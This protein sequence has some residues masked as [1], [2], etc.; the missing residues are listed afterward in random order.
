MENVNQRQE[1][2]NTLMVVPHGK[3]APAVGY[4]V[5]YD[6]ARPSYG[7]D[8]DDEAEPPGLLD[9]LRTLRRHKW[10]I[11][12]S[13]LGGAVL[14]ILAGL[15]MTPIYEASTSLEVL[16]V[17]DNFM[18]TKESSPV[19]TT[20]LT[21]E[22]SE[23]ETQVELLQSNAVLDR[24][25]AK[26]DPNYAK[27]KLQKVATTGWRSLFHMRDTSSL[28]DREV[29]LN[30]LADSLKVK[31][32]PRT[33]ILEVSARCKDPQLALEFVDTLASEFIE[34]NVESRRQTTLHVSDWL[35]SEIED[36]RAKL[37]RAEDALQAY[38]GTSGLI[39]TTTDAGKETNIAT[40]KLEQLQKALSDATADRITKEANYQLAKTSPPDA[41]PDVLNDQSLR[42]AMAAITALRGQIA[43]LN[44]RFTPEYSKLKSAQA[45]LVAL[46][47]D[48]D[49][50]RAAVIEKTKNDY[51]EAASKEKLLAGTYEAQTKEVAGQGEKAVQYNILK[52]DVES[53]GQLYYNMLQQ[54]KESSVASALHASNIRVA[55]PSALPEKPVWPNFKVLG[56]LGFVLGLSTSF[57]LF[58]H[59]ERADRTLRQPG[60]VQLWTGLLELGTVPRL[61]AIKS[62]Q[63]YGG[64]ALRGGKLAHAKQN[65]HSAILEPGQIQTVDLITW[66]QSASVVAESFRSILTSILFAGENGS[67]PRVLVFTSTGPGDGKT[68]VASNLAIAMSEI[69]RRVLI[70][71]ADLRRPRQHD[72]FNVPNEC[73]LSD[74]LMGHD[75]SNSF[76]DSVICETRIPG[77]QILPSGAPTQAAANMLYSPNLQQLLTKCKE[78]FDMVIIDTPPMLPMPDARIV[79]HLADGVVLVARAE[80]TTRDAMSVAHQRLAEDRVRIL[81]TVLNDW[82]P[83]LSQNAYYGSY[84][85][86]YYTTQ[87]R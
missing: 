23:E 48:F 36:A 45:Q 63:P 39:F 50:D 1:P 83:K 42:D 74:I 13:A 35:T 17:N 9:Y 30:K 80:Q 65:G 73:G 62:A 82:D 53:S 28:T 76:A 38:A 11:L 51:D 6:V 60:D 66:K 7:R 22:V 29:L 69:G 24:V 3:A 68:T 8:S 49:H 16:N 19:T 14:C 26:L 71:D 79:G 59:R 70:I 85:S 72:L 41:L 67:S 32:T 43:D 25:F 12:S 81:G 75:F 86:H 20:D 34:Q 54:L 27:G 47:A 21:Y 64:P 40:E 52:R 58:L 5:P 55:D 33:R 78:D 18:N 84:R 46:E 77:L 56:A 4:P 37:K 15:P 44:A 57:G 2:S 87:Q 10:K 31:A 61:S